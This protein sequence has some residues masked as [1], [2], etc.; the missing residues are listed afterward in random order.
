MVEGDT[1]FDLDD[2]NLVRR[3]FSGRRVTL[4][5][6]VIT[7]WPAPSAGPH[8]HSFAGEAADAGIPSARE[9]AGAPV[10]HRHA[11]PHA[12]RTGEYPQLCVYIRLRK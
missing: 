10:P 1:D 12:D 2:L 5:G 8:E 6:D 11:R 7:V 4:D 9:K 3:Q